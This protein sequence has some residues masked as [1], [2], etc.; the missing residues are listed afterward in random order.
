MEDTQTMQ[1]GGSWCNQCL[2]S[3]LWTGDDWRIWTSSVTTQKNLLLGKLYKNK[4]NQIIEERAVFV[5]EERK[6]LEEERQ[7]QKEKEEEERRKMAE[8]EA[9]LK[10]LNKKKLTRGGSRSSTPATEN[11]KSN[12]ASSEIQQELKLQQEEDE[13]KWGQSLE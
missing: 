3:L 8:K 11:S 6:K 5:E 9:K 2:V 13:C 1:Q 4:I 12:S 7:K 10:E